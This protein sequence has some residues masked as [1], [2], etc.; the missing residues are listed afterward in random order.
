[1]LDHAEELFL[2]NGFSRVDMEE[3][4]GRAGTGKA[5]V[6]RHFGSKNAL[7]DAVMDRYFD[8]IASQVAAIVERHE[9][10]VDKIKLLVVRLAS[11]LTRLGDDFWGD[12]E[13]YRYD[14]YRSVVAFRRH[15]VE[16]YVGTIV[17]R[18]QQTG[19]FRDDIPRSVVTTLILAAVERLSA[20]PVDEVT[21]YTYGEIVE[22]I[23]SIA[24]F[25]IVRKG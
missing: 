23:V 12:L 24:V 6:Y 8:R 20:A 21:T 17:E 19:E 9:S 10:N 14:K 15:L 11:E 16:D 1:M 25:G 5:T 22:M 3:V 2:R 7:F 4:A 18:G 13:R